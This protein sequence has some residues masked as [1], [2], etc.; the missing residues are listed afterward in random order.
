MTGGITIPSFI[1]W[2]AMMV[3]LLIFIIFSL[4]LHYHWK[5]YGEDDPVV[6]LIKKTYFSLSFG[7]LGVSVLALLLFT[8]MS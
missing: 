7:L 8:F 3:V 5:R 4:I 2:I 1:L 6:K